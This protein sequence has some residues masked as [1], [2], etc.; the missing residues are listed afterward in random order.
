MKKSKTHSK[1]VYQR[2]NKTIKPE[3][4]GNSNNVRLRV[5]D[6]TNLDTLLLNDIIT[7]KN[8]KSLDMLLGDYN[9]SGMVG[10][11]ATN[12]MIKSKS[13]GFEFSHNLAGKRQKVMGCIKYIKKELPKEHYENLHKILGNF[14]LSEKDIEWFGNE[15]KVGSLSTIID[16]YYNMWNNS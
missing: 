8:F 2:D 5:V 11:K 10:V 7:L 13:S 3:F 12:Y 4:I 9:R 1:N 15:E 16:R 6:Q 14:S